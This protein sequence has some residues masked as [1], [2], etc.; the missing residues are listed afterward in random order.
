[1]SLKG[2]NNA[3]KIWNFFKD[4]GLNDYGCAGLLGNMNAE[5]AL[6]PLNL[7]NN[8]NK[9]LGMTDEEFTA[10]VDSG[11][12]AKDTFIHDGYG[13]GIVQHTY[14]TRKKALYEFVK[15]AGKS[16][17]DLETQL[18]F[19]YKELTE[20]YKS[21]VTTLKTANRLEVQLWDLQT[22]V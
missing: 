19:V 15:S 2:S 6:N 10:A 11:A 3:E 1:M 7:Q 12:Y 18:L 22:V 21:L 13:Y 9:K 14:H 4:R 8:G 20:N 5:S 17:G 16:I